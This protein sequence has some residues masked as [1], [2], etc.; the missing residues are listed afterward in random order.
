MKESVLLFLVQF[1]MLRNILKLNDFRSV[2]LLCAMMYVCDKAKLS[3]AAVKEK[4]G[5]R[6]SRLLENVNKMVQE[7]NEQMQLTNFEAMTQQLSDIKKRCKSSL[8]RFTPQT[9]V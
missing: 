3:S 2:C 9:L 1:D 4:R 5:H 7:T 6:E 8:L